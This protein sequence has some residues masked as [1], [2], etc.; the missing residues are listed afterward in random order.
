M[1][2]LDF[3]F[4]TGAT[5]TDLL[6]T[7]RHAQSATNLDR[8]T[9]PDRLAEW[10]RAVG[11][12][13]STAPSEKDLVAARHVRESLR[14]LARARLGLEPAYA[15]PDAE[16]AARTLRHTAA[17][18]TDLVGDPEDLLAARPVTVDSALGAIVTSALVDLA[19]HPADYGVCSDAQCSK[20]FLDPAHTRKACCD[21]CSTRLRVRAYRER[22]K[23][24]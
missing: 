18:G 16:D 8:L 4:N 5:W 21:T 3:I 7:V 12:S 22:S 14:A 11:F 15:T 2:D 17:H 19:H 23:T 1:A 10:F 24:V 6:G 9:D 13:L 20:I